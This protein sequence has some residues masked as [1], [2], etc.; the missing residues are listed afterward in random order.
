MPDQ[1]QFNKVI[2]SYYR[3]QGRDLPWRRSRNP[4]EIMVSEVMLQ[5]T[6]VSRV[7]P[8]YRTFLEKYPTVQALAASPT[9][10][11]LEVWQGLGY[12][13][14]ALRLRQAA[15][16]ISRRHN[17]KVPKSAAELTSLPGIGQHTAGAILAYGYNL[18]AIF[19]ETN[20]RKTIIYHFFPDQEK[21]S[22]K[23]IEEKVESCLDRRNPRLWYWAV[24]D[25]GAMLGR[26]KV[27]GNERSRHYA[28]QP[29]FEGSNRQL[30]AAIV[31]LS[32]SIPFFKAKDCVGELPF[33]AEQIEQN[34]EELTKEG[35]L[36]KKSD[37]YSVGQ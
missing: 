19:I 23:E 9:R 24:V 28:K 26:Q 31:R 16:I 27:I 20:I 15:Q 22:D 13:R 29:R 12:N 35:F 33:P 32:L 37:G 5:Q 18:P 11:L 36:Q 7:I 8:Y 30:R 2:L 10:E 4:Y 25:Y 14:R 6:Q 21:V 1:D 34:L 3:Q 17:G